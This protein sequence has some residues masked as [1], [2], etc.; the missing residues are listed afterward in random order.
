MRNC[1]PFAHAS[2]TQSFAGEEYLIEELAVHLFGQFDH[3]NNGMKDRGLIRTPNPVVHAACLQGFTE[4]GRRR[5]AAI[6]F[7]EDLGG[8]VYF[9]GSGPLQ[10]LSPV[11]AILITNLISWYDPLLNPAINRFLSDV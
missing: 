10:Q 6:G 9:S 11:E 5:F 8:Y 4:R 2:R 1:D 7:G 3:V